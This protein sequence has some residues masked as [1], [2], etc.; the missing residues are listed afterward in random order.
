MGSSRSKTVAVAG[1][2]GHARAMAQL[3]HTLGYAIT[4]FYDDSFDAQKDE[5]VLGVALIGTLDQIPNN[6][7]LVL[8][9]GK[10]DKRKAWFDVYNR[11]LLQENLI[12]PR[13]L[14]EDSV[15]IGHA[16]AVM[17][18]SYVNA[19]AMLGDN[20]LINSGAVIEHEC[21][22][23]SHNHISVGALICGRVHIGDLCFIGA[24]AVIKNN[25]NICDHV[26]VGAGAV[27]VKDITEPGTY[28]G[29]PAQKMR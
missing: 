19:L 6:E 15:S 12:H 17:A 21:T 13:A 3:L 11:Q 18:M 26:T 22:I 20:N 23:G 2:G 9:V 27:V 5:Q 7:S 1:S 29:C 8:A 16:N 14:I 10:N 4:G 28:V 24:G 25:V